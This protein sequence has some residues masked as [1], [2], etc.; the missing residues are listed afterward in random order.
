MA[1]IKHLL[2]NINLTRKAPAR[3]GA[4]FSIVWAIDGRTQYLNTVARLFES[5]QV[6]EL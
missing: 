3:T 1:K 6:T 4:N 5:S 2:E